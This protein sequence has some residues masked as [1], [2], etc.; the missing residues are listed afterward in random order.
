M[1]EGFH[2]KEAR[3]YVWPSY[4]PICMGIAIHVLSIGNSVANHLVV[5]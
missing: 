3:K 4:R 2:K 1:D 5:C